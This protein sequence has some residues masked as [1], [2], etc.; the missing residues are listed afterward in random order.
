MNLSGI[1]S[2]ETGVSF[3]AFLR[4]YRVAAAKEALLSAGRPS[5]TAPIAGAWDWPNTLTRIFFP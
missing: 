3:Y 4:T 2:S 5:I 1:I